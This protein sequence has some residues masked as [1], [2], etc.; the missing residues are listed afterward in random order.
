M[1]IS[2]ANTGERLG[3]KMKTR[4]KTT[5]TKNTEYRPQQLYTVGGGKTDFTD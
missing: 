4:I 5:T 2:Y 3:L 1:T